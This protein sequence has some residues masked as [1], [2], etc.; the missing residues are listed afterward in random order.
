MY[1]KDHSSVCQIFAIFD[2]FFSSKVSS[3][4]SILEN[5]KNLAKNEEKKCL[6]M[7]P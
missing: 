3:E 7:N 1:L 4:H 5:G 6:E 2:D